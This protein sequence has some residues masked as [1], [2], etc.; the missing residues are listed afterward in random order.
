M[1]VE[2]FFDAKR[3]I[4]FASQYPD[5]LSKKVV[6]FYT[7]QLNKG[8]SWLVNDIGHKGFFSKSLMQ[9]RQ[10]FSGLK[11]VSFKTGLLGDEADNPDESYYERMLYLSSLF[12]LMRD[13]IILSEGLA[14]EKL[15]VNVP[16]Y[17]YRWWHSKAF[18]LDIN[19]DL[20]VSK[21]GKRFEIN[22]PEVLSEFSRAALISGVDYVESELVAVTLSKKHHHNAVMSANENNEIKAAK[23]KYNSILVAEVN[24]DSITF[25]PVRVDVI[26]NS[27]VSDDNY[28]YSVE[29][30]ALSFDF[31]FRQWLKAEVESV[32]D[33]LNDMIDYDK[34]IYIDELLRGDFEENIFTASEYNGFSEHLYQK[35][36]NIIFGENT[37]ID[38]GLYNSFMSVFDP[39]DVSPY[40][41]DYQEMKVREVIVYSEL[42]T[43][44]LFSRMFQDVFIRLFKSPDLMQKANFLGTSLSLKSPALD[45]G[46]SVMATSLST[47]K[48]WGEISASFVSNGGNEGLSIDLTEQAE[49][50]ILSRT[51]LLQSQE[52]I[53]KCK[54]SIKGG[55][56]KDFNIIFDLKDWHIGQALEIEMA[57]DRSD[58]ITINGLM[59]GNAFPIKFDDALGGVIVKRKS[60]SQ[61]E[62][63]ANQEHEK[64]SMTMNVIEDNPEF[65]QYY[66]DFIEK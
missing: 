12:L 5:G 61:L 48:F 21:H 15:Y 10:R 3:C 30:P 17:A 22:S 26:S 36:K 14:P 29:R 52:N 56:A 44:P 63:Y 41:H 50:P 31:D 20:E 27:V 18:E 58:R 8:D 25:A 54:I 38:M 32:N 19:S 60:F 35:L 59:S 24:M 28:S 66:S 9:L 45:G 53:E 34:N 47:A 7:E 23:G 55:K 64:Y 42:A 65:I 51:I 13:K 2:V 62:V 6:S 43:K 37:Q 57:I 1:N 39:K 40:D 4:G 46:R 49:R 16:A 11:I 33:S